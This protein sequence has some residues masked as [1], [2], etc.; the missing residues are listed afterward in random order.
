MTTETLAAACRALGKRTAIL[1][2]GLAVRPPAPSE[3]PDGVEVRLGYM[4]GTATHQRDF[5]VAV[6]ALCRILEEQAAVRLRVVGALDLREF[7]ALAAFGDRVAQRPLV[8]WEALQAEIAAVDVCLAPLEVGNPFCE[9][10]SEL[11]WIEAGAAGVPTVASAT[12][13][14]APRSPT[15]RRASSPRATRTGTRRSTGSCAMRRSAA[16]SAPRPA[17]ASSSATPRRTSAPRRAP[18]T[19]P[20]SRRRAPRAPGPRGPTPSP[21]SSTLARTGSRRRSPSGALAGRGHEVRIVVDGSAA[22]AARTRAAA[23]LPPRVRFAGPIADLVACDALIGDV[24]RHPS[25]RRP[26]RHARRNDAAGET[27][28]RAPPTSKPGSA[29]AALAVA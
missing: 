28:P 18:P 22:E 19:R 27:T 16:A 23:A 21:S 1:P 15:A 26:P 24:A 4:S 12:A 7:P 25:D 5:A 17:R 20:S 14:S 6:P 29:G 10:K 9:A 13:P 8:S 11:K 3:R 2:N